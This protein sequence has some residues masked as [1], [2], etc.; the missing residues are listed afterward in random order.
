M[1]SNND[2]ADDNPFKIN[3]QKEKRRKEMKDKPF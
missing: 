3:N 1:N 2:I